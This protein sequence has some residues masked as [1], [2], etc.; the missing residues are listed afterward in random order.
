M[1]PDNDEFVSE[2]A[3]LDT[4]EM[5]EA[6]R[7]AALDAAVQEMQD[8]STADGEAIL[9]KIDKQ[10]G[11]MKVEESFV[12]D[13]KN[14]DTI[15]V[16][17]VVDGTPSVVLIS[18][19]SKILRRRVPADT[20]IPAKFHGKRAFLLS[21]PTNLPKRLRLK[22]WLHAEHPMRPE[23]DALGM[24]GALCR[25]ANIPSEF[26]VGLHVET[27]HKRSWKAIESRKADNVQKQNIDS[28][29]TQAEAMVNLADSLQVML[30][31]ALSG[32]LGPIGPEDT[33]P[34]PEQEAQQEA[35]QEA[36]RDEEKTSPGKSLLSGV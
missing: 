35:A 11:N 8:L 31:Q 25:K 30:K 9:E 29:A 6:V 36:T 23:L 4:P 5:P 10:V 1:A 34:T 14:V 24:T 13:A 3:A 26:E 15:T 22:C 28:Q 20:N 27:K 17:S 19:L 7:E 18:M 21:R 33:E 2:N 16:Y 12:V 32:K